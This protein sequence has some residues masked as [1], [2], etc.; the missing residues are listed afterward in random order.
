MDLFDILR[1]FNAGDLEI[2]RARV[3]PDVTYVIPGRAAVS[4]EFHGIDG[5][6]GA[7]QRLRRL[8]GET[9]AVEPHLVVRDGDAVMFV[10]QVTAD[11]QGRTLDV[12]N[13]Y[14]FQFQDGKLASGRLFPGDL[15]A[16]EA[17]LG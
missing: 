8:S 10:A 15:H 7:F 6:V 9:I 11:H 3:T 13:A 17:F 4:G 16:I 2:L 1:A 14:A 12:V 5:V